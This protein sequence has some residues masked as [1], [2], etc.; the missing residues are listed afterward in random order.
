MSPW[1]WRSAE[2][3][4]WDRSRPA[5]RE[6]GSPDYDRLMVQDQA[7]FAALG[8]IERVRQWLDAPNAQLDGMCPEDVARSPEGWANVMN[9]L[10]EVV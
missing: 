6:F 8:S 5:G 4:A 7:A 1:L 3:I 10:K 9:L 2:D